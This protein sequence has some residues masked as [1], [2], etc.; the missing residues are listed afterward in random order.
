MRE[1]M[2]SWLEF[3]GSED[4]KHHSTPL[5]AFHFGRCWKDLL[6][7]VTQQNNSMDFS[8]VLL[9]TSVNEIASAMKLAFYPAA[10]SHCMVALNYDWKYAP[11]MTYSGKCAEKEKTVPTNFG[12]KHFCVRVSCKGKAI[13]FLV[14]TVGPN[15][16]VVLCCICD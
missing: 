1:S 3:C 13:L 5:Q 12:E 14:R 6:P 9:R 7:N 10:F 11:K 16:E 2:V 4:R 8:R 15:I